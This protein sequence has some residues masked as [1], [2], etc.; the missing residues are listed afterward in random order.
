M[1]LLKLE[2]LSKRFGDFQAVANVSL[3]IAPGEFFGLLGASGSGKTTL[4]RMI[5]GLDAPDSGKIFLKNGDITEIAPEKRGFGMVFQNYALF[6]HLDVFENIAFGLK[7]RKLSKADIKDKVAEALRLVE[8]S[9]FERR[10]ITELSGGQ[11]QRAAIARAIA[12]EP[13]L[14]LFDEPFSNLD[15]ALREQTRG[16][17]KELV[18]KLDSTALFVTHDQDEVFALCDRLGIMSEGR[19]IHAGTPRELYENPPTIRVA[20]LLGRN[21]LIRARLLGADADGL[22]EFQTVD[23]DRRLSVEANDRQI[24]ETLGR[25]VTLAIRPENLALTLESASPENNLLKAVV[26]EARYFGGAVRLILDADRL[27]LEAVISPLENL[28]VGDVCTVNLPPNRF[29]VLRD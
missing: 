18:K 2:N 8:L 29:S 15:A 14:L 26:T 13:P 19:L 6:P 23:G 5:A 1:T 25:V 20:A 22:W 21:N 12:I 4:L 28:K 9:G 3:A 7:A 17:L 27:P 10:R 16:E 24:S 11:Q